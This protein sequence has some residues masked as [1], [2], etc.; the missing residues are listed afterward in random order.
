MP[1][2][3]DIRDINR[4]QVEGYMHEAKQDEIITAGVDKGI[5]TTSGGGSARR[6]KGRGKAKE[7]KNPME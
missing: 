5:E 4:R 1:V 2:P 3:K 7:K 6:K